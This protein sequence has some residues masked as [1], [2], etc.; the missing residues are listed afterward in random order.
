MEYCTTGSKARRCGRNLIHG[1]EVEQALEKF[2]QIVEK[3]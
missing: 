1:I 3:T 2:F